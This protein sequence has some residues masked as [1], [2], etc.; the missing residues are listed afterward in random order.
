MKSV[1]A[2]QLLVIG[3]PLPHI[4]GLMG[5]HRTTRQNARPRIRVVVL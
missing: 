1:P 2:K 3:T 4:A 5:T